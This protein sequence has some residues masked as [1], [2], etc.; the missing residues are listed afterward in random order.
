[1]ILLSVRQIRKHF[2]PDPLL[3]G[4]TFDVRPEDRVGLVGPNGCGKTTLLRILAGREDPDGGGHELHG[5]AR[6]GYLEQQPVFEP[7]R[8]L[9]DEAREALRDLVELQREAIAVADALAT[10]TE[11]D[12]LARLA[13]RYDRLQQ[14]LHHRDAYNLDYKI[15]R[16][17]HGLGFAQATLH[18]P[19]DTLSGGEQNRLML[20]RL[21]LAEPDLMLLDEPSNHLDLEAT[22]WLE[23]YLVTCGA[24]VILVSHDRSSL[25]RITNR[26][27]E[28]FRGTVE[29][30]PGNF[31]AYK[32]Q[33]AERL[34]VERRTYEKQQE[35]IAKAEDFIR[36]NRYGQK[37]AQAEDR[38]KKLAR[39]EPVAP[40]REITPPP[41]AFA[42]A[43][44]SGD[45]VLRAERISKAFDRVLFENLDLDVT[46]GQR[47]ALI[48]P[49]GCGKTTLL[50]CL[51][52]EIEP[53]AGRVCLGQ[54]VRPGYFDQR[55]VSLD[56][57]ASVV[58]AVRPDGQAM[59]EQKRRDLLAR[60]GIVGPAALQPV[61][62][63]SGG[64]RC[65]AALARLAASETNLLVLDEPTN[66]LDLWA[67][68]ALEAALR[69]FE[70]TVF[71]VSHDRYLVNQVADHLLVAEPGRFRVVEGN[72][73]TYQHLAANHRD[74]PSKSATDVEALRAKAIGAGDRMHKDIG[75]HTSKARR[76]Q[77]PYRKI[78]DIERQILAHESE[79]ER[80][81]H[82]LALP[83]TQR[84]G[85]R[86][87]ELMAE[88]QKRQDALATLHAHWEEAAELNW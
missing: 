30:Y 71:L 18:Q 41:M 70:G 58:D 21:L 84:A 17:L 34:L 26:T 31:S 77:F 24:A 13:A 78:E 76:R 85:D 68:E 25:D 50:R 72:Y 27:L 59:V 22:A 40:P 56:E 3:D 16:V 81:H 49:N 52:G 48:G 2:G 67:R 8:T 9:W 14:E 60:F 62:R 19:I 36:R 57:A 88:I 33:K 75:G 10:A 74:E 39:I 29:F 23:E 69:R 12:E 7:G 63:L 15:K 79:I 20:A 65:R 4:V 87:R 55:L 43:S 44:R 6:M 5:S 46:R 38:R 45:V 11:A 51:L 86:V 64:E 53:D 47:W 28:L 82:R 73:E 35:E 42:P 37:H 83:E 66:H 54:G 61:G 80:L 32:R 1:M